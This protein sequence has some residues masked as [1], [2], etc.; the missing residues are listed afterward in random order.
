MINKKIL[1]ISLLLLILPVATVSAAD[2]DV[3]ADL[4]GNEGSFSLNS[5]EIQDSNELTTSAGTFDDLQ[6]EI[7]NAPEDSVLNLTRDY[8][9]HKGSRIQLNKDLT[10]DGQGHTLNCLGESGCSAFYSSSGTITLKNLKIIN[11]HNNNNDKG[12]AIYISG[13]AQYTIDNCTFE[14]NWADDN[15]GAIYNDANKPLMIKNCKFISNEADGS[16]L[17]CYGGAIYSVGNLFIDNSLFDSNVLDSTSS[18]KGGAIY[19][20][21]LTAV[22]NSI[23]NKNYADD[24]GGAIYIAANNLL[25]IKNCQFLSNRAD[26]FDGGAIYSLGRVII[27]NSVFKDNFADVMGGAIY[28]DMNVDLTNC[29]FQSNKADGKHGGAIYSLGYVNVSGSIFKSNKANWYGGAIYSSDSA[30]TV[31]NSTFEDNVGSEGGALHAKDVQVNSKQDVNQPFNSFFIN[32]EAND[33]KGGA[34]FSLNDM[35][36]LNSVFTGNSANTDGGAILSC[37]DAYLFHCIFESNKADGSILQSYGGAVRAKDDINIDNCTFKDNSTHDYGGALYGDTIRINS[38]S[39]TKQFTSFFINNKAK[40]NDGGAIYAYYDFYASNTVFSGNTAYEDGG[41]VFCCDNAHVTNCLFES[42]KADGANVAQCEGGAIHCKDD[43]TVD[44]CTFNKN[45]AYD[46]GGAIYADTL[47]LKG[48]SY[49]DSNTAH[50]NQGGAIWVNK[51][52]ED[53]KYAIF[54]NNNAGKGAKDDGGAIYIDNENH[55]TFSQCAFI[56]NYCGD[57]G[58]AIYLDSASS[59]LTLKNNYFLGNKAADEGQ[60]VFNCGYYDKITDNWWGDKQP[61]KKMIYWLNGK[62]GHG[63]IFVMLILILYI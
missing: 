27:E 40:D 59:H 30:I 4:V 33:E 35:Y 25:S 48:Y 5:I 17:E 44:N 36:V 24:Y 56:N 41:A 9:G 19:C 63:Q 57:E 3:D 18:N 54:T 53:V 34:I 29:T 42:N 45:Y 32:N 1:F 22:T 43:L 20:K 28:T 10:I 23:F 8:D 31:D 60:A 37:C 26:D 38:D 62:F 47:A 39:P 15:G 16:I 12:G 7:N 13:S 61:S 52:R 50:D 6:V 49:F 11:G 55:I 51:F 14:K 58:G 46:Y 2:L 21:G